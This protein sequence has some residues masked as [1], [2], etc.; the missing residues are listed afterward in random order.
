MADTRGADARIGTLA[1]R[2]LGLVTVAQLDEL[3]MSRSGLTRR[4]RAGRLAHAG[5]GVYALAGSPPTWERAALA[6]CLAAGPDA[7]LSHLTAAAV[8]DLDGSPGQAVHVTVPYGRSVRASRSGVVLHRTHDWPRSDRVVR[9]R[10]TVTSVARTLVDVAGVIE[11]ERLAAAVD[12]ALCRRLLTPDQLGAAVERLT[13]GRRGAAGRLRPLIEPWR[14]GRTLDSV[15]EGRARRA[16]LAAGLPPPVV[17]Y[18]I[19]GTG[20]RTDFAWPGRRVVLEI[21]GFRWHASP[22]AHARDS[23]RANRLA[24]EGW[25]V[26][27]A[28]PTEMS[29]ALEGVIAALRRHLSVA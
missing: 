13:A 19:E 17:Q 23:E 26:L 29:E 7:A 15:A 5:H 1:G 12:T 16:L 22:A 9:G 3:G 24:A 6:A 28:T 20:A 4:V 21:D 11:S 14:S 10:L 8:W 2:Q 25:T 18:E 27:R